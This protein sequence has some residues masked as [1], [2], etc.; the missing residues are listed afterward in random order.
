M[1]EVIVRK[2]ERENDDKEEYE[3]PAPDPLPRSM[4]LVADK[5]STN[6]IMEAEDNADANENSR[7]NGVRS[8][9]I[10]HI[11]PFDLGMGWGPSS[12]LRVRC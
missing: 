2:V 6:D 5:K 1:L 4:A 9:T 11:W 7:D 12:G 3:A 10:C 8:G